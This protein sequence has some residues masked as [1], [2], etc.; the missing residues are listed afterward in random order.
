M[1]AVGEANQLTLVPLQLPKAQMDELFG[2]GTVKKESP[3]DSEVPPRLVAPISNDHT[4]SPAPPTLQGWPHLLL[5]TTTHSLAL[6]ATSLSQ[7]Y[8]QSIVL[9]CTAVYGHLVSYAS[10]SQS[11]VCYLQCADDTSTDPRDWSPLQVSK[12]MLERG[13]EQFVDTFLDHSIDGACLM[14]LDH[15]QLRDD[16]SVSALGHRHR[17]LRCIREMRED[18]K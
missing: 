15:D 7:H 5:H 2:Y 9:C 6:L 4:S 17:I 13:L 18:G 10:V 12:W 1:Q 14:A 16:L 3:T 11:L 8:T